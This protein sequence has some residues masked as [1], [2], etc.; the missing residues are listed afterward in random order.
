MTCWICEEYEHCPFPVCYEQEVTERI[1]AE[2]KQFDLFE[3][4][5]GEIDR[6]N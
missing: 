3:E 5:Y 6:D 1:K 2:E 4:P